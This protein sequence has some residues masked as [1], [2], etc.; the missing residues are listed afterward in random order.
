VQWD[1][2]QASI[3]AAGGDYAAVTQGMQST[4]GN[5]ADQAMRDAQ[6]KTQ[7]EDPAEK[8]KKLG[9]MRDAGL[10]TP[11]EFEAKKKDLL[12]EM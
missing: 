9:E 10:I 2:Q 8:L 12:A 6:A 1:A 11:D 4:Y 3:A 7:A 5:V